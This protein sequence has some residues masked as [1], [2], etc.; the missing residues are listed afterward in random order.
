M[1]FLLLFLVTLLKS[2]RKIPG[3]VEANVLDSNIEESEFELHLN[4]Y[5]HFKAKILMRIIDALIPSA[6]GF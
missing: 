4:V 1:F 3:G 6:M 5:G 2:N